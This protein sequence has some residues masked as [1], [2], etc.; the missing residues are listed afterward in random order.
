M[1]TMKTTYISQ[2][3]L[4][5]LKFVSRDR[6]MQGNL[7]K[8]TYSTVPD[9]MISK[10]YSTLFLSYVQYRKKKHDN[11]VKERFL[12]GFTSSLNTTSIQLRKI[13]EKKDTMTSRV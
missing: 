1:L 6:S 3:L 8:G 4:L 7:L 12:Q 13:K 2:V 11:F 9:A 10:P 5:K